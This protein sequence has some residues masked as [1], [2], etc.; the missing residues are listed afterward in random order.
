MA[1]SIVVWPGDD[2][3][4][5]YRND[6]VE[7]STEDWYNNNPDEDPGNNPAQ[8]M[9]SKALTSTPTNGNRKEKEPYPCIKSAPSS[10]RTGMK[11]TDSD[12]Q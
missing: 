12:Q 4:I 11:L 10:P 8:V 2:E 5:Q 9:C 3:G 7:A 6:P 1:K